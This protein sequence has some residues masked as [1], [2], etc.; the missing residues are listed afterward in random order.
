MGWRT[1][2]G[3]QILKYLTFPYFLA[4]KLLISSDLFSLF[5]YLLLF[6][7]LYFLQFTCIRMDKLVIQPLTASLIKCMYHF[8]HLWTGMINPQKWGF[9]LVISFIHP[10]MYFNNYPMPDIVSGAE[11]KTLDE[12][13]KAP[14]TVRNQ[15]NSKNG[16]STPV[17]SKE[18][19]MIFT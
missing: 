9:S 8:P 16:K 10:T 15:K 1:N 3:P 14:L 5:K 4:Q 13:H 11:V 7:Q 12:V 17:T 2:I 19:S 6:R 18:C